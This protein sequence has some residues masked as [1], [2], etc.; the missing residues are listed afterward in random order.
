MCGLTRKTVA[1]VLQTDDVSR[2][3]MREIAWIVCMIMGIMMIVV[4]PAGV[5]VR[6]RMIVVVRH[7]KRR[8]ER[9]VISES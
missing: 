6:M 8:G 3:V 4:M 2:S 5:I 1:D 7:G 9:F